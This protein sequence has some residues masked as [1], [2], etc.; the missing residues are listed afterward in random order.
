M[1]FQL[2]RNCRNQAN[3]Q[4]T[5]AQERTEQDIDDALDTDLPKGHR[6]SKKFLQ[7]KTINQVR[8]ELAVNH[9]I[10]FR[11]QINMHALVTDPHKHTHNFLRRRTLVRNDNARYLVLLDEGRQVGILTKHRHVRK[12]VIHHLEAFIDK[13]HHALSAFGSLRKRLG[14]LSARFSR[15]QHQDV[16]RP[17]TAAQEAAQEHIDEHP[18]E[19]HQEQGKATVNK[20]PRESRTVKVTAT[21]WFV[22]HDLAQEFRTEKHRDNDH[23]TDQH[24]TQHAQYLV[25]SRHQEP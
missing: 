9:A 24:R 15:P 4:R 22:R 18:E 2:N 8:L 1:I 16:V 14:N 20:D 3:R 5:Q 10:E 7:F 11:H 6:E 17:E 25:R 19:N 23:D 21:E 13:S 12:L